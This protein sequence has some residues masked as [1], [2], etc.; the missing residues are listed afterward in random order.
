MSDPIQEDSLS[1]EKR[2]SETWAS[3]GKFALIA[4]AN[5]LA[6]LLIVA[7]I[8]YGRP[9]VNAWS[10]SS[11]KTAAGMNKL[12]TLIDEAGPQVQAALQ[13]ANSTTEHIDAGAAKFDALMQTLAE[14]SPALFDSLTGLLNTSRGSIASITTK[15]TAAADELAGLVKDFNARLNGD[16]GLMVGLT[17][18]TADLGADV[19]ALKSALVAMINQGATTIQEVRGFLLNQEWADA[20]HQ[21]VELLKHA[22]ETA[23]HTALIT[24]NVNTIFEALAKKAPAFFA[25]LE[26]VLK[27][28]T[29]FQKPILILTVLG[30]LTKALQGMI[31]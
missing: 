6:V 28:S 31:F 25:L 23:A 7:L 19:T 5:I 26:K 10:D 27:T 20:R 12:A 17:R 30:L 24:G 22:D 2:R 4:Q 15:G 16:F 13:H 3:Y 1:H 9:A 11:V 18:L 29:G 14:K 8:F 21:V